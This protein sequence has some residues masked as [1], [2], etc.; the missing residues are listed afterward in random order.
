MA[1]KRG[2]LSTDD[3]RL[4]QSTYSHLTPQEI[5]EKLNRPVSTIVAY[6]ESELGQRSAEGVILV[7]DTRDIENRPYWPELCTQFTPSELRQFAF[8]WKEIRNQF[9]DDIFYTEELQIVELCRLELLSNRVLREQR[10]ILD[11]AALIESEIGDLDPK[12]DEVRRGRERLTNLRIAQNSYLAEYRAIY[13]KKTKTLQQLKATRLDRIKRIEEKNQ[14]FTG[15]MTSILTDDGLRNQLATY[16][17]KHRIATKKEWAR[18][19]EYHLYGDS[20]N[21]QPFLTPENVKP[22]NVFKD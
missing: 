11:E 3:K 17:E 1:T 2:P 14:T 18:L 4:I 15:W 5:A 9:N 13:D 19:S 7:A 21:D 20:R 22:D 6:I 12:S 8:H 10:A 16:A